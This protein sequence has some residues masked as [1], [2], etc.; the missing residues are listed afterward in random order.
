MIERTGGTRLTRSIFAFV[1]GLVERLFR[2]PIPAPRR[3]DN[4]CH[5]SI[6]VRLAGPFRCDWAISDWPGSLNNLFLTAEF[7]PDS[8]LRMRY[9]RSRLIPENGA[10]ILGIGRARHAAKVPSSC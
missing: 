6:T 1:L 4:R 3:L 2:T 5:D 9:W 7:I 8:S 10:N